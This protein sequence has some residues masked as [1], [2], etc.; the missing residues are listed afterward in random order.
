[1]SDDSITINLQAPVF[2]GKEGE[3]LESIVKFHA[4]LATKGCAE[5]IQTNFK[6]KLPAT[7][8]EKLDARPELEKLKILAKMKNAMAMAF[9]TQCFSGMAVLN[10]IFNVQ[11]ETGW[12]TG[13]ACQLFDNLKQKYNPNDKLLRAQTLKKLNKI[14]PKRG[15]DPKVMCVIIKALKVKCWDQ[16]D[17][18][19]NNTIVMH[20]FLFCAKL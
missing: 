5:V 1:M 3:W 10:V 17:I 8:D 13:K 11:V 6:S 18:L 2:S 15:D 12:L 19:D 7:E 20:L 4:F 16:A 14:K 9:A